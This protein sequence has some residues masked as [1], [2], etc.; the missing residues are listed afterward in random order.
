[1]PRTWSVSSRRFGWWVA[2]GVAVGLA[3]SGRPNLAAQAPQAAGTRP[4]L[5]GIWRPASDRY[6]TNL[7]ADGVD[8]TF[9]PWAAALFQQRQKAE[10]QERPSGRCR[11][12]GV[13]G[14]MLVRAFPWK[15]VQTPGVVLILFDESLHYRQIFTDGRSLPEDPTPAWFGYSVGRWEGETLVAET[16]GF[17]EETWLDDGGHP[18]SDALHVIERF[19]RPAAG[20]MDVNITIDD[21]K[22]YARPWTA[23]VRF[24]RLPNVDLSEHVCAVHEIQ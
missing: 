9:Q 18:H 13:P 11:P 14:A 12:R 3:V 23:S 7:A 10:R 17:N 8:V 6:A 19:G 2:C 15:I 1:M 16:R 24:E 22:A 5:S 20:A 21:P 4:D